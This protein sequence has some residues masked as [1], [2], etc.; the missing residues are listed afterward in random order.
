MFDLEIKI[1]FLNYDKDK[2]S[3]K[4]E[5]ET[6]T[7]K[8]TKVALKKK[9]KNLDKLQLE[10]IKQYLEEVGPDLPLEMQCYFTGENIYTNENDILYGWAVSYNGGSEDG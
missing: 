4:K 10:L 2:S 8:K 6:V 7:D 3:F 1:L 5:L 9:I